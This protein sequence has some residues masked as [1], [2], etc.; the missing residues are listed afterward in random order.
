MAAASGISRAE[1][2]AR[3]DKV[4]RVKLAEAP[5]PLDEVP[6]LAGHLGLSRL[7]VKRDDLTGLALGG[8]KTRNYEFRLAEVL[9]EGADSVIMYVD[10]L[11]NSQRQ[12]AAA[13]SQLGLDL[14]LVLLGRKPEIVTGNLLLSY[15][16]GAQ[17]TFVETEQEQASAAEEIRARL[18]AA[19]R[20][21][22]VLNDRPMFRLASAFAYVIATLEVLDQ[23]ESLGVDP[24]TVHLYMSSSGKGQAGLEL[25]KHALD[26]GFGVTGVASH[27]HGGTISATL[28]TATNEAAQ[29]LGLSLAP[30]TAADID[31]REQYANSGRPTEAG[32]AALVMA[33]KHGGLLVDPI[34]NAKTLVGLA[35]DAHDGRLDDKVPV[36]VHTGGLPLIFSFADELLH[37]AAS[38]ADDEARPSS[39][40]D[41]PAR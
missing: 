2:A 4:R 39:S 7:F 5:T 21:P 18:A 10:L 28:A 20:H 24:R 12:L 19:G 30:L 26:I 3:V 9:D 8:N 38:F 41:V 32:N 25:V 31:N 16:F 37:A 33:A 36:F 22:V 6:R 40:G 27:D 13:C 15:L 23:L 34:Y 14:Y 1:L 17:V 35:D 29:A 11:S